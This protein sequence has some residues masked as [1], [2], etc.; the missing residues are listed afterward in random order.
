M[1]PI[2]DRPGQ[3]A[4][5]IRPDCLLRGVEFP[6][7]RA[8][9]RERRAE[10]TDFLGDFKMIHLGGTA[11]TRSTAAARDGVRA[12]AVAERERKVPGD[13]KR[14]AR[15]LDERHFGFSAQEVARGAMAP[16]PVLQLLLQYPDAVGFA[17]GGYGEAGPN[18]ISLLHQTVQRAA[19]EWRAMGSRSEAEARGFLT[20]VLLRRWG[21]TAARASARVRLGRVRFA[22]LT[23]AQVLALKGQ[24]RRAAGGRDPGDLPDRVGVVHFDL[25][26][27][28]LVAGAVGRG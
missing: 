19:V 2:N 10:L 8:A 1:L 4:D 18:A 11:Y 20:A 14:A 6:R 13:Y 22:G 12:H 5:G 27:G 23:R 26:A 7:A 17:F 25:A 16:G 24:P 9:Q 28:A 21:V 15:K 3:G